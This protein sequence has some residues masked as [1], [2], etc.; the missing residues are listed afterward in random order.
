M[1]S[2]RNTASSPT[3]AGASKM[4]SPHVRTIPVV[5]GVASL[6]GFGISVTVDRGQLVLSDGTGRD[7]RVARLARPTS[8]LKRLVVRGRGGY[9]TF[10]ALAWLHGVGAGL[11]QIGYDGELIA[12]IG[13]QGLNDARLRRA[14]ALAPWNGVGP[15][16]TRDLLVTKLQ[17]QASVLQRF[18]GS[19]RPV[20]SIGRAVAELRHTRDVQRMRNLEARAGLAYWRAWEYIAVPWVRRDEGRVPE[21]WRSLGARMSPLSS[22]KPRYAA[23]PANAILN[24][25]YTVLEAEATLAAREVGL[26]PGMGLLHVDTQ[27]RDS[28]ALDLME[29]ARPQVDGYLLDLLEGQPFSTAMFFETAKGVCRVMPLLTHTL[30][31]TAVLWQAAVAPVIERVAHTLHR[32]SRELTSVAPKS[33]P[34]SNRTSRNWREPPTRLTQ[35]NRLSS[36][37]K[38]RTTDLQRVCL[39]CGNIFEGDRHARKQYCS[40]CIVVRRHERAVALGSKHPTYAQRWRMRAEEAPDPEEF[41]GG[42]DGEWGR[43]TGRIRSAAGV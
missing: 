31:K 39:E 33:L 19:D 30:A 27:G 5:Q 34:H 28:L 42:G 23:N 37:A 14:Q 6:T 9:I 32:S 10:D 2:K 26:D 24:Y 1:Q 25:T 4:E 8:G 38:R 18:S 43:T 20:A 3:R 29:A 16:I 13:R 22:G 7:H 15:A 21:H 17:G 36:V 35:A 12:A 11:V 41:S 40:D